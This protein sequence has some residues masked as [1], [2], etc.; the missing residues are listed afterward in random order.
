MTASG[1]VLLLVGLSVALLVCGQVLLPGFLSVTQVA[2]QL[3][4]AAFLGLFALCQ[5]MAMAAGGQ[6]LDLSVGLWR[7][8]A[9]SLAR[10]CF[11]T[12]ALWRRD[13]L[14]LQRGCWPVC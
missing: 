4:I 14:P 9:A 6:G 2:N 11:R 7:R 12:W 8:W 5:T 1:R 13:V 10:R 3:K